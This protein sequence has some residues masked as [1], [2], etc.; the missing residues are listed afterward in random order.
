MNLRTSYPF[1]A[2]FLVISD[3][4]VNNVLQSPVG[5]QTLGIKRLLAWRQA[6]ALARPGILAAS[7]PLVRVKYPF[8]VECF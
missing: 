4:L 7:K 3:V 1:V 5:K 2:Y 6:T 8:T